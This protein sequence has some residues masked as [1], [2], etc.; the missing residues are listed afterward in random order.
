MQKT[1]VYRILSSLSKEEY[2]EFEKFIVSPYFNRSK[3]LLK[4]FSVVKKYYPD[5]SN[6]NLEYAKIYKKLY[7]GKVFNEG[8]LRNLFSDL[9]SLAEKFLAYVNYEETFTYGY[10]IISE[11]NTRYLDK[12]FLKSYKKYFERKEVKENA[13]QSDNLNKY[14]IQ[15]EMW[16]Y[17]QRMNIDFSKMERNSVYES[18]FTFFINEFLLGQSFQVYVAGWYKGPAEYNILDTFFEFTDLEAIVKCMQ[19]NKSP[20]YNEI[21]LPYYLARAVQNK[22]GRFYENFDTAYKIFNEQINGMPKQTQIRL[23]VMIINIINMHIKAGDRYLSKIKFVLNK[24]M[25]EKEIALDAYGKMPAYMFSITILNAIVA[26]EIE[27]AKDFL[28]NKIDIVD[29]NAKSKANIYNYYKAKFLSLQK[30]YIES[31]E[32][33]LKISKDDDTF[34]LDSKIL[35]LINNYELGFTES[36]FSHAESFKQFLIRKDEVNY[37]RKELGANFLKYYMLLLREKTGVETDIS[38]AQKE[39]EECSVVRNKIWLLQKFKEIETN[40]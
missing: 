29:D 13:F 11:T 28:E 14:Q 3:D 35:S 20:Y 25:V 38:F 23:Y 12:E 32:L 24:E 19:T 31:N 21:K 7:P 6:A 4:L 40:K 39:L 18:L 8:T 10:K 9:G 36:A 27:W 22:D 17:T 15:S 30:K 2:S 1:K 34:K 5:F 33:L 26:N 37:G 16:S